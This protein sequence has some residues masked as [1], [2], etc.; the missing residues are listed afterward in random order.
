MNSLLNTAQNFVLIKDMSSFIDF[1]LLGEL[2]NKQQ[3]IRNV[4]ND[5]ST[6][7]NL[8]DHSEFSQTRDFLVAECVHYLQ[9][10]HNIF[11]GTNFQGLEITNSW[12]NI[13]HALESHHEHTH[14][15]SVVSGVLFLDDNPNNL[16]LTLQSYCQEVP[17]YLPS[18][19]PKLSLEKIIGENKDN[20]KN[21]LVLFLSNVGHSVAQTTEGAKPR[22][23]I[24]F[25]TFWKGLVGFENNP[26]GNKIF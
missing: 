4:N 19:T 13:T 24:S 14:P 22:R 8:L 3:Y 18:L 2:A 20:L 23:T 9:N 15:F 17:Y 6:N 26:L 10:T 11:L 25:N 16:N 21:H 7:L 5:I 12:C 1:D